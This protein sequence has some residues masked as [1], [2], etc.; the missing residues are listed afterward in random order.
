MDGTLDRR[1]GGARTDLYTR[2][3]NVT[4]AEGGVNEREE[5]E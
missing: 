1:R 4:T 2:N 3:R 5:K